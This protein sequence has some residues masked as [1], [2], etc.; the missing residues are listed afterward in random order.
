MTQVGASLLANSKTN[1]LRHFRVQ[2]FKDASASD[3]SQVPAG[4]AT[5][6]FFKQG[7][8]VKTGATFGDGVG[9]VISLYD[10]GRIKKGDT[11][12][13]NVDKTITRT[14][15]SVKTDEITVAAG[16][17]VFDFSGVGAR[18]RV[19]SPLP[20]AWNNQ[21]ASGTAITTV[22]TNG[23]GEA[24]FWSEEGIVDYIVSGSGLTTI[25]YND[26]TTDFPRAEVRM[27]D[28]FQGDD[29]GEKVKA[30]LNDL[31]ETWGG[32]VDARGLI[33]PQEIAANPFLKESDGTDID[34]PFMILVGPAVIT[35]Q[36][37]LVIGNADD[38]H[39]MGLGE[40]ITEIQAGTGS[41]NVLSL[42]DGAARKNCTISRLTINCAT[43]A[44]TTG[45]RVN[46]AQEGC[47]A[48][49]LHIKNAT[50]YALELT[51]ALTKY[52]K[53]RELV[54]DTNDGAAIPLYCDSTL[55]EGCAV[56][57]VHM[58]CNGGTEV[59]G[60]QKNNTTSFTVRNV[61]GT[62]MDNLV[63]VKAQG[64]CEVSHAVG[65]SGV[66]DV[67]EVATLIT[68]VQLRDLVLGGSTNTVND[69]Q[70]SVTVT[71]DVALYSPSQSIEHGAH[72]DDIS[73]PGEL[74]ASGSGTHTLGGPTNIGGDTN[75][76]GQMI[77]TSDVRSG[78]FLNLGNRTQTEVELVSDV[79]TPTTS[80]HTIGSENGPSTADDLVTITAT[81]IGDLLVLSPSAG[82]TITVKTTGNVVLASGLERVLDDVK[83]QVFLRCDGT[84]WEEISSSLPAVTS[85]GVWVE[86]D[87]G[88]GGGPYTLTP[89]ATLISVTGYS[90]DEDLQTITAGQDGDF[91][92]I[93]RNAADARFQYIA[94]GNLDMISTP[95]VNHDDDGQIVSFVYDAAR[96]LW[97]QA[98]KAS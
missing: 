53:G 27:A 98:F 16:S 68:E 11:V 93:K 80:Y 26:L 54:L 73:G 1:R 94:G 66:A 77:A 10:I 47:Y 24:E 67:V 65:A 12:F 15:D 90:L 39:M 76:T 78:G 41:L 84:N 4:S 33:G 31:N 19:L 44:S 61:T 13:V 51:N 22:S 29:W 21:H 37:G 3:T 85:F 17:G 38:Q 63:H 97:V 56:D 86:H 45:L 95:P 49:R 50:S 6:E 81:N 91:I 64:G 75:I 40:G 88:G 36:V 32:V 23:R 34:W 43:E 57:G 25:G 74:T 20:K 58:V 83:D 5:V 46:G 2:V 59:D 18:I 8:G 70:R 96:A 14:V 89:T 52:F 7:A 28:M 92:M 69:V 55:G 30:A 60:I 42:A 71:T 35:T 79:L 82:D 87:L 48:D 9:G 62:G 72:A